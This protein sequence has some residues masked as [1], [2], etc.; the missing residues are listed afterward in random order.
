MVFYLKNIDKGFQLG[1]YNKNVDEAHFVIDIKNGK[2]PRFCREQMV[3]YVNV[4]F[5]REAKT[6]VVWM[7]GGV[8]AKVIAPMIIFTNASGAHPI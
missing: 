2:M 4:V 6:M 5:G 8:W 1:E 3:K 7:T